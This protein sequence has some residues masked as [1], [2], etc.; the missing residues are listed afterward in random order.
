MTGPDF[1]AA[2][3]RLGLRQRELAA[4]L[5]S[6]PQTI[7]GYATD[8]LPIPRTLELLL[9]EWERHPEDLRL[10]RPLAA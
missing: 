4:I 3:A 9:A 10:E 1:R 7:S 2:L 5:G 6:A 8:R